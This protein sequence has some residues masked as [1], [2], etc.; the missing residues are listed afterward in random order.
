MVKRPATRLTLY[1][2]VYL[3]VGELSVI[4]STQVL[5]GLFFGILFHLYSSLF[6]GRILP[7]S[8]RVTAIGAFDG[9]LLW[10]TIVHHGRVGRLHR[11]TGLHEV[12][13]LY[14][15]VSGCRRSLRR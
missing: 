11:A 5:P 15:R 8:A 3:R 9:K 4:A 2:L 12:T 1:K 7:L 13:S 14:R 6:T 10:A